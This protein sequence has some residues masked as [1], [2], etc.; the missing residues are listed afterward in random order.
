MRS[1]LLLGRRQSGYLPK[2]ILKHRWWISNVRSWYTVNNLSWYIEL[3][4]TYVIYNTV[5]IIGTSLAKTVKTKGIE[6]CMHFDT[7]TC[8]HLKQG[9]FNRAL[10][11]EALNPTF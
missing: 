7:C 6:I 10:S 2:F 1:W 5:S 9:L 3:F 8:S 4:K 11:Q